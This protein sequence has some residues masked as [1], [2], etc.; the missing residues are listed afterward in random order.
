MT[1]TLE[2][3]PDLEAELLMRAAALGQA[4]PDYLVTLAEADVYGEPEMPEAERQAEIA[5]VQE[6]QQD[7]LSG[8]K[9]I[10]LE[11]YWAG[12]LAKRKSRDSQH[13]AKQAA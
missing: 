3:P 7:R 13:Q 8:D 12:V 1:I 4:V 5:L 10:L 11:D 6:R 2:L 9:G